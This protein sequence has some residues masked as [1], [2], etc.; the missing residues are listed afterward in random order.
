MN[1]KIRHSPLHNGKYTHLHTQEIKIHSTTGF[2]DMKAVILAMQSPRPWQSA[3]TLSGLKASTASPLPSCATSALSDLSQRPVHTESPA[4]GYTETEKGT[5]HD[6]FT[7]I[8]SQE[9]EMLPEP[10]GL[11]SPI[12]KQDPRHLTDQANIQA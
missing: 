5:A 4:I 2:W 11:K 3:E 6:N 12:R 7:V 10:P 8:N 1:T 9:K